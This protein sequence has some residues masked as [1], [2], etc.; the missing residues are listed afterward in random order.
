MGSDTKVERNDFKTTVETFMEQMK[1]MAEEIE[2]A[3][4]SQKSKIVKSR[5][6]ACLENFLVFQLNDEPIPDVDTPSSSTTSSITL[7]S[8]SQKRKYDANSSTSTEPFADIVFIN[9]R[10][11]DVIVALTDAYNH[12]NANTQ[13]MNTKLAFSVN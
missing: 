3:I 5:E 7:E 9:N 6:T 4:Q 11:K 13:N 10:L 1:I 2:D 12:S 8:Q